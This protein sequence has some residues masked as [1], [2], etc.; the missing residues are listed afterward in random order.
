[1]VRE[2][3]VQ[4]SVQELKRVHVIRQAMNKALRQREAGEVLGLTARQVRRLIQRV[5]AE[6]DAGLVHRSRGTPSNRRY[7]PALK[8]RV[9]R[10]Y[11]KHYRD[12]GPT[13]AAEKL[14]E[15]QGIMLS[16]ETLRQWLRATG[17]THF[18]RRK[19][20]HR[21]WRARKAHVGELVQLD[22]SHHD[23]FEGRGPRC[24][25]MAYIDD[26]SSRVCARFYE[27]EG[28][29]PAM[30]SFE[31]YVRRYGVPHSVYTDKHT[32]YRAL[33][34]PTVAQQLAGEKPQSQFERALAELGVTVIHAHSPQAKGRVERLFKTLQ[35]RL[36]KDLRLAGLATI[37]AAN[38]F[39]ET[40][41]PRYNRRFAVPPAQ[42]ADLHRP[43]PT[44][45]ELDR[46]LCL[47]MT[48]VV[49]RD[50]TVAHHGQLFQIETQIHTQAVLVED[51]LD[52]TMRITHRGQP[53]RYHA[54]TAR[55]VRVMAP[56][57]PAVPQ[58]PVKP[59][60]THP[61]HRRILSDRH[62]TAAT[63]MR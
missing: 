47:K 15:Q 31:R 61:W 32:T 12:F 11:A 53:L 36:V 17:V 58:R 50:W 57:P 26:A 59:K 37:E 1:M 7:R 9:L 42:A 4:M 35:D 33:G 51:H 6:G 19:R 39:V 14:A 30:D 49:R 10:L 24:V 45:R 63:P 41:L 54:I 16:A 34:E 22:G 60:P 3:T 8:A 38:Q 28:T 46:M 13:L 56:T 29:I 52:G 25:L 23:W 2:E 18:Q 27:Y 5:R 48:R 44:A 40:W 21:A 43:S 20:P 62:K 55:S